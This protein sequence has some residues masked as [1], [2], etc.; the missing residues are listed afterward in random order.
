M[1]KILFVVDERRMGGV[2][3]LLEDFMEM[4]NLTNK[5][6]DIL[7]LHNNGDRLNNLPKGVKVIYGTSYFEVVDLTLTEVLKSKKLRLIFKKIRLVLE[8]KTGLIKFRIKKE[9]KKIIK[10]NYDIEIAF[11]D[12][13][14]ALFVGFGNCKNKIHWLHYDYK[15]RNANAKY[16]KLFKKVLSKFNK[17]IA[18]SNG[19]MNDFNKIYNLNEKTQVISNL[20][21][22]KKIKSMGKLKNDSKTKNKIELI[23]V[24]RLHYQKGYDRLIMAIQKLKN[25][26]LINNLSLKI[27][28][29]GPEKNKLIELVDSFGLNDT[30]KFMGKTNNPYDKIGK[31]DLFILSSIYEPFGLVIV[32]AM[33]LGVPVIATSNSATSE[34]IINNEN[35]LIV[36]NSIEGIYNGLRQVIINKNLIE[37]YK[38]NLK[39]YD[40]ETKNKKII[41]E[42]E[43]ILK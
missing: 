28:G 26:K 20:I 19:V 33:T 21:N 27:Y 4:L 5:K 16:E 17:I 11:K 32:E 2:S 14:T 29:D 37:K 1:K 30:I 35:G 34:L 42:I 40:Y 13:F 22:V 24:G 38:R 43:K 6:I 12:G 36:N 15:I 7:V 25:D 41:N 9:R 18:V 31:S 23:S 10:E 3:I 8:M 39:K